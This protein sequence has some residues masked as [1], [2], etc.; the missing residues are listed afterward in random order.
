VRTIRGAHEKGPRACAAG[1][2]CRACNA[3]DEGETARMLD[4]FKTEADKDG[5][6][7]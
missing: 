2:L 7:H 3:P 4:G 6:R 5:W 1:A